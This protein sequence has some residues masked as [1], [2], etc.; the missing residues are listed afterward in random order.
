MRKTVS[1]TNKKAPQD[2]GRP[3]PQ[4]IQRILAAAGVDS[5]RKCE[6]L[7]LEGA[8]TVNG[9][10]INQ[11]PAFANP[12]TDDIRVH[13]NRILK[14]EK[15]YF[16]LNKPKNVICTNADPQGRRRAI[17]LIDCRE[18][19]FCVGRLD[20]E[21]TGAILLTNDSELANRLTHPRYK[22]PKTYEVRVE[23]R[24]ES[25]DIEKLKKG[26]WL[27]EGKTAG[28][29]VKVAQRSHTETILEV[30]INQGLNRQIRRSFAR[31]G[32][33]VRSLKRVMIGNLSIKG[34]PPGSYKELT[35]G[36]IRGL[37]KSCIK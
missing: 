6:T 30:V 1:K 10:V 21:T 35:E 31:L 3:Q 36:Q 13:G 14:P 33:K 15:R 37:S 23:G 16:L 32:F 20:S 22:V 4:R 8:V 11:L 7:I 28:A 26:V 17:D 25:Q 24:M 27:S 19:I 5:R 9:K 18:R 12:L 2:T 34:I 29:F